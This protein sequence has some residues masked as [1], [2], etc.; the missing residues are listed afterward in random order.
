MT[1]EIKKL[2]NGEMFLLYAGPVRDMDPAVPSGTWDDS[3]PENE[4]SLLVFMS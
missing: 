2:T 3:W 4:P 1:Y